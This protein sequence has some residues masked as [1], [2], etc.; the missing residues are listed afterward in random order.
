MNRATVAQAT[1]AS[2]ADLF[3][4]K[5]VDRYGRA[6]S[7]Y[8]LEL[9][10]DR[11]LAEDLLQETLLRA[12]L[13]RS[14]LANGP[15]SVRGWLLTVTRNLAID[16]VRLRRAYPVDE[17]YWE[18]LDRP[19]ADHADAV[20]DHAVLVPALRR[21]TAEHRDVLMELYFWRSSVAEAAQRFGIPAGTVK[22]RA[23]YALR[24][25]RSVFAPDFPR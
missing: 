13:H 21:L 23:F 17:L 15:G 10:G 3:Y 1:D 12:W 14:R 24:A 20:V 22:S 11:A 7:A 4:L 18:L 25:L 16:A 6:V 8:A 9:T 5:L 19:D 2:E